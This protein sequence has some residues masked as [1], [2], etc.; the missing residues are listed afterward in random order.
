M[1][2]DIAVVAQQSPFAKVEVP[3]AAIAGGEPVVV[4]DD[5]DRENEGDV[6]MAAELVTAEQMAFIVRCGGLVCV[7]LEGERLD[8]L[9]LP[10]MVPPDDNSDAQ[11]TSFTISVDARRGTTTGISAADRATTVKTLIDP[12]TVPND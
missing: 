3:P 8:D 4:V 2:M 6:I 11:G 9:S 10:L 12:A 1:S 7:A 5:A